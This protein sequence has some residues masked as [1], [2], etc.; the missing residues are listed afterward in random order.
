MSD[1]SM[2]VDMVGTARNVQWTP[3]AFLG[4]GSIKLV[5]PAKVNLFLAVGERREDG[6]HDV[7]NIMQALALH[8]ILYLHSGRLDSASTEAALL[9]KVANGEDVEIPDYFAVVGPE[10]NLLVYIDSVDKGGVGE[11]EIPARVNLMTKAVDA[12]SREIGYTSREKISIRLEK[13]IPAQGGLGGGS[14]DAAAMLVG[15]ARAWGLSVDDP[16]LRGVAARLGADVAFFLDGGCAQYGG[17]GEK[18]V[19]TM[20]S[21]K[22]SVL[23]IKPEGGVSTPAAYAAFDENPVFVDEALMEAAFAAETAADVPLF[24]GLSSAAESLKPELTAIRQWAESQP[25]VR[26]VMLCGSGATTFA[27][28]D[29][30]ATAC[31]L[32]SA[33][34]LQGWWARAT[35]M[36]SL[37]AA[38]RPR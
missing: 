4:Y 22:D 10:N 31:D 19:R 36:S 9:E 28:V 3:E 24:N 33:A 13:N 1:K 5:A 25:G 16:A 26:N 38:I 27:V 35:M 7:V 14:S 23:L 2:K 34:Q 29:D 15:L 37:K 12:L 30:F 21:R 11:L 32:A 17:V 8:D 18:L 20:P 6:Y